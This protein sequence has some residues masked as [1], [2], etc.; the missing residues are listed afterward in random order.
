MGQS[1]PPASVQR[2]VCHE[3][4]FGKERGAGL[5]EEKPLFPWQ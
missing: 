5:G 2:A 3:E 4:P 1:T